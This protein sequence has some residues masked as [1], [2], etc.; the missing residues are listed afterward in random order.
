MRTESAK[1]NSMYNFD[2]AEVKTGT[3]KRYRCDAFRKA[4]CDGQVL[5]VVTIHT[6]RGKSDRYYCQGCLS[7]FLDFQLAPA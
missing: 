6:A 1:G 3:K 7:Y 4:D 2:V 5:V